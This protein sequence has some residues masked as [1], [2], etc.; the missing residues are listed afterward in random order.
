MKSAVR[1]AAGFTAWWTSA[2]S[3]LTLTL[4]QL[5]YIAQTPTV[6]PRVHYI[7]VISCVIRSSMYY[8]TGTFSV[9]DEKQKLIHGNPGSY[10]SHK[11]ESYSLGVAKPMI[12]V[13]VKYCNTSAGQHHGITAVPRFYFDMYSSRYFLYLSTRKPPYSLTISQKLKQR[14]RTHGLTDSKPSASCYFDTPLNSSL[15]PGVQ[16]SWSRHRTHSQ[17]LL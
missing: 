17:S 7:V 1:T 16:S 3:A 4:T 6:R 11:I 8:W 10:G 9:L 14:R 15:N 13:T 12:F 2:L 5:F